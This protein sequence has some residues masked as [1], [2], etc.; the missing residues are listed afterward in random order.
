[1]KFIIFIFN[2]FFALIILATS[3]SLRIRKHKSSRSLTKQECLAPTNKWL[4]FFKNLTKRALKIPDND[5]K[6]LCTCLKGLGLENAD[7]AGEKVD[8]KVDEPKSTLKNVL[9]LIQASINFICKFKANIVTMMTGK[10][11]RRSM[12]LFL[13]NQKDFW[14]DLAKSA[15]AVQD[16][17]KALGDLSAKTWGE[18]SN[19]AK[20]LVGSWKGPLRS[21]FRERYVT[22]QKVK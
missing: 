10:R 19:W 21:L 16:Q 6:T 9:D 18:V 22:L 7:K 12:K 11:F 5:L 15:T 17:F 3:F 8:K 4:A 13:E 2:I 14:G 20:S 1:M